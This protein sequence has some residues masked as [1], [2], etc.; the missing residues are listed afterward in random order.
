MFNPDIHHRK[1]IRLKDWDYSQEG[2]YFVT[3]CTLHQ[4]PILGRMESG[5]IVLSQEG[6]IVMT[7]L[8]KIPHHFSNCT[9][10]T[11]SIIPN[12]L[13]VILVLTENRKGEAS[14]IKES[15]LIRA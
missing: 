15:W 4:L 11:F 9:L 13:H 12:H 14:E 2:A 3:I 7:C 6:N 1:S 8:G 5:R 10:D